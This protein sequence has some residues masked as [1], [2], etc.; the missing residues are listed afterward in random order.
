MTELIIP[1]AGL[2]QRF[3]SQGINTPKPLIRIFGHTMISL[4]LRNLDSDSISGI[5][6]VSRLDQYIDEELKQLRRILEKPIRHLRI[7][8]LPP[9]PAATLAIG[10]KAFSISDDILVANC[11]Q[12]IDAEDTFKIDYSSSGGWLPVFEN[13]DP[14][15]S[16]V[17]TKGN[18]V[19]R[20]VEKEPVSNLA[21]T[22]VYYFKSADL[23]LES[24]QK[25]QKLK[26]TTNNEYY[27]GPL[28]NS[29]ISRGL[30]VTFTHLGPY[31]Q[32]FWGVGTPSDLEQFV[33]DP[34]SE[35]VVSKIVSKY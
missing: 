9:G 21:T 10:L 29:L 1:M 33:L 18:S 19:S 17:E 30:E 27:V 7:D 22:G 2:G 16:Y 31:G 14:K 4:V 23:A 3:K 8:H 35:Q 6:L 24:F 5:T 28:Y 13:Q 32:R 15:W 25:M 34:R 11:D 20:L 26:Q 12:L